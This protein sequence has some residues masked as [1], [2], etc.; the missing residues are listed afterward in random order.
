MKGIEMKVVFL[1]TV[2]DLKNFLENV[3]DDVK[4]STFG[5]DYGCY[6]VIMHDFINPSWKNGKLV[7]SHLEAYVYEN[8]DK[9][10]EKM[11]LRKE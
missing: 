8:D 11:F 5:A 3:G 1:H 7:L 6:A 9:L 4:L 10:Y 2:G